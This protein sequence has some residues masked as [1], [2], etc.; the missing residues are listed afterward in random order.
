MSFENTYGWI[1]T[2]NSG[3]VANGTACYDSISY[4]E[5]WK[6]HPSGA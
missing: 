1:M 2:L 4:N 5:L 3:R 6:V